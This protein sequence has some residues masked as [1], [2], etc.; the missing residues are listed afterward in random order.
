MDRVGLGYAAG[1]FTPRGKY[2]S[3]SDSSRCI[4]QQSCILCAWEVF[5]NNLN[6][7]MNH[8]VIDT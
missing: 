8:S 5:T 4:M 1:E 6:R 7:L 3:F 2:E